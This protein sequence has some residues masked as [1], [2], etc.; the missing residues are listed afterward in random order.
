MNPDD[1]VELLTVEDRFQLSGV[2]LVLVPDFSVPDGW[3]NIEET[4]QLC[5]PDGTMLEAVAQL[6]M[7]HFNIRDPKADLDKRWRIV[8]RLPAVEKGQVPVGSRLLVSADTRGR[9]I[10]AA[11]RQ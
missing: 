7:T 2:G 10:G 11:S 4:V 3:R 9:V 8:V 1:R 5:R 6:N